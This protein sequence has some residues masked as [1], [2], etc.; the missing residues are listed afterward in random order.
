MVATKTGSP[1]HPCHIPLRFPDGADTSRSLY[2]W[3]LKIPILIFLLR[4]IVP[5]HFIGLTLIWTAV[6]TSAFN[7]K[8]WVFFVLFPGGSIRNAICPSLFDIHSFLEPCPSEA[9]PNIPPFWSSRLMEAQLCSSLPLFYVLSFHVS[10]PSVLAAPL[11]RP[12]GP[13]LVTVCT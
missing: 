8:V 6:G 4:V 11:S 9:F 2:L 13:F 1:P 7:K 12:F 10:C 5:F 3:K